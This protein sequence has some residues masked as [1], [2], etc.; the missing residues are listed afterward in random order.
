MC[1]IAG[2]VGRNPENKIALER[3]LEKQTHRGPDAKGMWSGEE[4]CLGHNRLSILDLSEAANQPFF[5]SCGRFVIVFNGEIYNYLELKQSLDYPFRT[6]S[7]TE[8]LL[9][10]YLKYRD[11]MINYLNGMFAFAIWDMEEKQLFAARDRFGVKPFY[12]SMVQYQFVFASEIKTLFAAGV[13]QRLNE[14]VWADYFVHGSYGYP[15]E[16]F[17]KTFTN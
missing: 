4:V 11:N 7:D 9:A 16:T 17:S 6:K 3:M 1:G 13:H 12:Y 8:V 5:S 15:E 14:E 2:I 10:M